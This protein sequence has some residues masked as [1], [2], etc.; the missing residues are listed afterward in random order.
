[1]AELMPSTE[2]ICSFG[3]SLGDV[4]SFAGFSSALLNLQRHTPHHPVVLEV[5]QHVFHL[6]RAAKSGV[7]YLVTQS[8]REL[9]R[10]C[11]P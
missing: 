3:R 11:C 8:A 4:T 7:G 9:G 2:L 5:L 10:L 6:H 1:M